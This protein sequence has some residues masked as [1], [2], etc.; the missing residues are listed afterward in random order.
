MNTNQN[1]LSISVLT[2]AVRGVLA[3]MALMPVVAI[4]D[5]EQTAADQTNPTNNVEVG[6]A[7]TSDASAKFGEYNGLD[8]QGATLI[9]NVSV[10]GGDGYG[11]GTGTKRWS[12]TGTDLGTTSREV[13]ATISDQGKWNLGIDFDQLRHNITDTYQTPYQGAMGGNSFTLPTSDGV[14]NTV[15]SGTRN[16]SAWNGTF[17]QQD[18]YSERQN[19]SFTAGYNI[20]RQWSVKFDWKHIDQSG[21]K[22]TGAA[23][24]AYGLSGSGG[25]NWGGER[26]AILMNPTSFKTDNFNLALS[27]TG[28]KA[29]MSAGYYGSLFHDDY[30]GFSFSNPFQTTVATGSTNGIPASGF[31]TDTI[32]TAP[33]NQFHQLN[34]NGGYF[35]TPAT[36]LVGGFSYARNTQDESFTGTYTTTPNTFTLTTNPGNSLDG[37]VMQ[38]H[39]DLTL[40]HQATDALNLTAGVKYNERDNQ[41]PSYSYDFLDL[42]GEL[43][44]VV[45]TPMSYKHT[46]FEL[47]GD[48]RIDNKQHLHVAYEYDEMKRWCNNALAN[49]ATGDTPSYNLIASCVQVPKNTENKLGLDYKLRAT[50]SVN[51][52]A[53][54]SYGDRNADVNSS[55][56]NPMQANSEGYENYG[57]LA[58]F[59][60]S[61]KENLAKLGVDWQANDKLSFGLNGKYAQEDYDPTFGV[62]KGTTSSINL[63]ASYSY[64]ENNTV[65]AYV[66]SQHRTRDLKSTMV[67]QVTDPV[68]TTNIWDNNLTDDQLAMGISGRQKGLM[69]G[70][71]EL[72]ED[73]TYS[74]GKT[75]YNTSQEGAGFYNCDAT[76]N[77]GCGALPTIKSELFQLRVSGS[78]KLDKASKVK[79]G[80][81]YQ[82]MNADDYFYNLYQYGYTAS[83]LLPTNQQAPSYDQ[84]MVFVAYSHD[85]K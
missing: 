8:N 11:M 32:S 61:R 3:A 35:I 72:A 76:H 15:G 71:L 79:V 59:D 13:G 69:G 73:L 41:T 84:N 14:I 80:Y 62:Q 66:T 19:T 85:F 30:S 24:D 6:V 25:N 17:H 42:G 33:S 53:G 27:W 48:Y 4:A 9:G 70:R 5:D 44:T 67:R 54:Y 74:L 39:A 77:L 38:T 36:K 29:Y 64:S 75:D 21:S 46:Q 26:I 45:N 10:K 47:A 65:S 50:D 18:V 34:L 58:F 68:S 1:N 57:Y 37:K 63:D 22:L 49:N 7:A 23:T 2:L 16:L 31:P 78:Y 81:Q 12:I 56:Y 55:F 40:T 52:K 28:D 83:T 20:D 43:M 82:H 51:L 60:A